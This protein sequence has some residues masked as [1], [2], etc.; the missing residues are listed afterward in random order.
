MSQLDLFSLNTTINGVK[1]CNF[2]GGGLGKFLTD[3]KK[4]FPQNSKPKKMPTIILRNNIYIY[5]CRLDSWKIILFTNSI[6][7][8]VLVLSP[9][10]KLS[11]ATL[12]NFSMKFMPKGKLL[13]KTKI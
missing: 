1:V 6:F 11:S 4:H 7:N 12:Q 3:P 10:I 5:T 13:L 8:L 2:P 9:G